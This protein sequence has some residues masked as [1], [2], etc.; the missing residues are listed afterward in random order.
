M[1]SFY[2]VR[3]MFFTSVYALFVTGKD[4][5]EG[6]RGYCIVHV[7]CYWLLLRLTRTHLNAKENNKEHYKLRIAL[8]LQLLFQFI[9]SDSDLS[10]IF[11]PRTVHDLER[12]RHTVS[13]QAYCHFLLPT[14]VHP[15]SNC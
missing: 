4:L 12:L 15:S 5:T 1:G 10:L 9:F 3:I 8:G 11:F 6:Y 13:V 7:V 14:P 2:V